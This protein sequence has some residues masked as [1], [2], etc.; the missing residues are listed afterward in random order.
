MMPL[1][2]STRSSCRLVA[3]RRSR[4]NPGRTPSSARRSRQWACALP[5]STG[6]GRAAAGDATAV[7]T[8]CLTT[9]SPMK[10]DSPASRKQHQLADASRIAHQCR[11]RKWDRKKQTR[12]F[13]WR[14]CCV[15]F[16]R[17]VIGQRR[18][19]PFQMSSAVLCVVR[20]VEC[21]HGCDPACVVSFC[22]K[23]KCKVQTGW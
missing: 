22:I 13:A 19:L 17:L 21:C 15:L 12:L 2:V 16:T 14:V 20:A 23:Q 10:T 1:P 6:T 4:S 8:L 7:H 18:C 3:P 11:A 9:R 5:V